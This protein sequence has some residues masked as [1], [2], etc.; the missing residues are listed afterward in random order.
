MLPRVA[1]SRGEGGRESIGDIDRSCRNTL[2]RGHVRARRSRVRRDDGGGGGDAAV[3]ML[4][5]FNKNI[6]F[7]SAEMAAVMTRDGGGGGDG[8]VV[9]VEQPVPFDVC[10][11]SYHLLALDGSTDMRSSLKRETCCGRSSHPR[12]CVDLLGVSFVLSFFRSFSPYDPVDE[13]SRAF[14][15]LISRHT[16]PSR[17]TRTQATSFTEYGSMAVTWN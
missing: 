12:M 4:P 14:E 2:F 13:L 15:K 17:A 7:G 8:D 16:F 3:T 11:G 6:V 10:R 1:P 9:V 5:F